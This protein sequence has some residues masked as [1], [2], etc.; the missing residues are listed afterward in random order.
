MTP[1]DERAWYQ[2]AK[3][4]DWDLEDYELSFTADGFEFRRKEDDSFGWGGAIL[5]FVLLLLS[6]WFW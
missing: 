6:G 2:E 3:N 1:A 4:Q 5:W